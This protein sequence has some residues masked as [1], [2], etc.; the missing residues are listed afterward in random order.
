MEVGITAL[1]V[2]INFKKHFPFGNR[3]HNLKG[4]TAFTV[5][6]WFSA[7]KKYKNQVNKNYWC[8]PLILFRVG[9]TS[10]EKDLKMIGDKN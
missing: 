9:L 2:Q 7:K 4:S 5:Y 8:L 3:L 10:S 1:F 6:L